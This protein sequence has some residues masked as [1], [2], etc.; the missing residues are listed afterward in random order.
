MRRE[1]P[2]EKVRR[3]QREL[4]A[5][6]NAA[7]DAR[8]TTARQNQMRMA[9][10]PPMPSNQYAPAQGQAP[11][12]IPIG[13]LAGRAQ[14]ALQNRARQIDTHTDRSVRGRKAPR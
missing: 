2:E 1:T 10:S 5:R 12:T 13:G 3:E 8:L 14:N 7:R 6:L 4:I 11:N 9:G